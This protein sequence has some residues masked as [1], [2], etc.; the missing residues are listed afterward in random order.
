MNNQAS[1]LRRLYQDSSKHSMYQ[2]I[3][4]FVQEK[5]EYTEEI[6]EEWRGDTARYNYILDFF[7]E[8]DFSSILD[9]GAN[10]GFFSHSLAYEFPNLKVAALEPNVNHARFITE[11]N[12]IFNLENMSVINTSLGIDDV[13]KFD[14]KF[15]ST[16][17]LN[18]LHHA[19]VEFDVDKVTTEI[20]FWDYFRDFLSAFSISTTIIMQVGYNWGGNKLKPIVKPD[21]LYDMF[22]QLLSSID[23]SG[24]K[25]TNVAYYGSEFHKYID[26]PN[27]LITPQQN[28]EIKDEITCWFESMKIETN[29]EFYKRPILII[30]KN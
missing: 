16:L 7:K 3:P 21:C 10:T 18:V 22:L 27:G 14:G 11:I 4:S 17:L 15:D 6:N 12:N 26:V 30:T 9:I 28:K 13:E 5:L 1:Q 19:G 24:W 23:Q 2:S 20:E 25:A 29:S 8:N